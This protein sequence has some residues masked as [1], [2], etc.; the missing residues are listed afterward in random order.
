MSLCWKCL[1]MCKKQFQ[2]YFIQETQVLSWIHCHHDEPEE[3]QEENEVC[4][5]C[6]QYPDN[7]KFLIQIKSFTAKTASEI[8]RW[9]YV[10][11]IEYRF[12]PICGKPLN[13]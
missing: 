11:G 13:A 4:W 10:M 5:A 8:D 6:S 1:E 3:K 9:S 12:C 7:V 2:Q